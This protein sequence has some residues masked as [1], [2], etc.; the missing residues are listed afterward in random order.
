MPKILN[1]PVAQGEVQDRIE[2]IGLWKVCDDAPIQDHLAFLLSCEPQEYRRQIGLWIWN[3]HLDLP[4]VGN[5]LAICGLDVEE[6]MTLLIEGG[7][8]DGLEVWVASIALGQP[9]NV[10]F[11]NSLWAMAKDGFDYL[12]T[13]L[14][15]T[16][17]CTAVLCECVPDEDQDDDLSHLGAAAPPVACT[18]G[19]SQMK[20]VR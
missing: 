15:L 8:A 13:S 11:D 19:S 12:Y 3:F 5:W 2:E 20:T 16:S 14:L 7:T 18:S 1:H 6:Y 17:Y 10:I 4:I 9:L